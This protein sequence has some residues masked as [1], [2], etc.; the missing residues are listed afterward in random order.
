MSS[1]VT[2]SRNN[3]ESPAVVALLDTRRPAGDFF[4][5]LVPIRNSVSVAEKPQGIIANVA[6][7]EGLP[8]AIHPPR[9][10][11]RQRPNPGQTCW[12]V[13][14]GVSNDRDVLTDSA[15][16]F[17]GTT[18]PP[19]TARPPTWTRPISQATETWVERNGTYHK[20]ATDGRVHRRVNG[21]GV[22]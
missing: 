1:R 4:F 13:V 18:V 17:S 6:T 21:V 14:T 5:C 12:G 7:D 10:R 15:T 22:R 19:M 20:G 2:T 16:K 8:E 9:A 3:I 11:F